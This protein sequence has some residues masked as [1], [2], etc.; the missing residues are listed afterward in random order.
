METSYFEINQEAIRHNIKK[1]KEKV[2]GKKLMPVIKAD[3]YGTGATAILPILEE[4]Q[5][6]Q[7]AVATVSE[8]VELRRAG[9]NHKILILNQ[10]WDKNEEELEQIL[11]QNLTVSVSEMEV[12]EALDQ[13]AQEYDKKVWIHVELD[14]GMGRCGVLPDDVLPFFR[15]I[16][17]YQGIVLEGIFT[18]F[19][20]ADEEAHDYTNQQINLFEEKLNLLKKEGFSFSMIHAQASSGILGYQVESCNMVR[21]GL[22]LYGYSPSEILKKELD[23]KP[24]TRLI[25]HIVYL[26]EV[27]KDTAIS[28]GRTYTTQEKEK[29]ATIPIGYA[30][31]IRRILSNQGTVKIRGEEVPIIGNIC[32]DNFMVEV[33]KLP[34][35]KVGDEVV[36]WEQEMIEE[37]AQKCHTIPYEILCL[38]GKRVPRRYRRD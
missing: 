2:N 28:Y 37:L 14:T 9:W 29:I 32:M 1:I 30:D 23:L 33:T 8:A 27:P 35:V 25:S 15:K 22:I 34:D 3:G 5:I 13:K 16:K 17:N 7:V 11:K 18:H 36:I 31:G 4:E 12:I 21:P 10:L 6:R 24:A 20:S 38:I 26:K 19:S